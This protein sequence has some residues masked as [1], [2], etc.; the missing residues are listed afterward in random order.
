MISRIIKVEVGVMPKLKAEADNPYL[1]LDIY[2]G[3]HKKPKLSNCFT[4]H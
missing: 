2:S 4:T 1:D 3:Y